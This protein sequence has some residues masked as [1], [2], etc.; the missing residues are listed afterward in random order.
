[1]NKKIYNIGKKNRMIRG[2]YGGIMLAF[3]L[4]FYYSFY[5]KLSTILMLIFNGLLF[6]SGYMGVLQAYEGFCIEC[7]LKGIYEENGEMKNISDPAIKII[8]K[9][10]AIKIITISLALAIITLVFLAFI[11]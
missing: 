2:V 3:S 11:T 6:L 4:Y 7:G 5:L 8:Y 10:K 1:M 9:W